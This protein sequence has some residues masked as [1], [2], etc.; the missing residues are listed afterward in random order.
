[1]ECQGVATDWIVVGGGLAGAA[2]GYELARVGFS[3]VLLEQSVFPQN[4][5][6]YSYGG[7][8][9]WSATTQ[10]M[11]QICQ[12]GIELHRSLSAELEADTQFRELDLLLTI[13]PDADPEAIATTYQECLIPP[14][15]ISADTAV[16][17]E[18]LL[19]P[20]AIGA[21]LQ[22]QHGHVDPESM[23]QAYLQAVVRLGG[24]VETAEVTG[25]VKT[26]DRITGVT[27]AQDSYSAAHVVV[28]A[29]GLSRALLQ[30][31]GIKVP[32]YF[33]QAEVIETPPL[34]VRLQTIVMPA[35]LKRFGL[36]AI[37]S[38][39]EYDVLWDI[40][41]HEIAPP[42]LDAGVIQLMDGRLRMGQISRVLTNA[43]AEVDAAQSEQEIRAEVGHLLPKLQQVP[44]QWG[45]C[46]V[47]FSGDRL[48]LVGAVPQ[49]EGIYIF[50]G[51]SNPFA[52]LPP[53]ARHFAGWLAGQPDDIIPQLSPNRFSK[54]HS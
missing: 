13:A 37:A 34:E 35:E 23:V 24:I 17:I 1:M 51:F 6:R 31:A 8:S 9:Y 53:L 44:G 11:R 28:C 5:T 52:I 4:A 39:A 45:S 3:V 14:T 42:I 19:N 54:P 26:G 15:L 41:G 10:L 25:F 47:A 21:A 38:Q 20:A 49:I 22:G 36:E 7:I 50:S 46:L 32:C 48:P 30:T 33:T 29:G 18:P 16:E 2:L 12:E 43:H 40:P 27:T